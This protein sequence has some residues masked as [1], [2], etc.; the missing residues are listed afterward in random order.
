[1]SK[2]NNVYTLMKKY[3]IAKKKK[4]LTL[5]QAFVKS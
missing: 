3:F 1:M 5:I 2:K 4:M